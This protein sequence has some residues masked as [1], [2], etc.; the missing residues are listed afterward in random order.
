MTGLLSGV[1]FNGLVRQLMLPPHKDDKGNEVGGASCT[2]REAEE[3]LRKT[4]AE[5]RE[6]MTADA[7]RDMALSFRRV[8]KAAEKAWRA[9]QAASDPR[10]VA[11]LTTVV[12]QIEERLAKMRGWDEPERMHVV[13][14]TPND[15][16]RKVLEEFDDDLFAR[17]AAEELERERTF[18]AAKQVVHL[19]PQRDPDDPLDS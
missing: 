15:Q 10:I 1:A 17:I 12:G 9:Q 2:R 7:Q 18:T 16:L 19:L 4:E 14:T 13:V 3:A 11:R 5:I 8:K 6:S